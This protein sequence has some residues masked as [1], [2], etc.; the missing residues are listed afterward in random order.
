MIL[1]RNYH[2]F[3][4]PIKCPWW[5]LSSIM[6]DVWVQ[7]LTPNQP[8]SHPDPA[9]ASSISFCCDPYENLQHHQPTPPGAE[10]MPLICSWF[11]LPVR[12]VSVPG[13]V[14][15]WRL[16]H[17]DI[18]PCPI[19]TKKVGLGRAIF[20]SSKHLLAPPWQKS[21]VRMYR[22]DLVLRRVRHRCHIGCC[23]C[24]SGKDVSAIR[25]W[26]IVH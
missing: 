16:C 15:W 11:E 25:W 9:I 7:K 19:G 8:I 24:S 26:C 17:D 14:G 18:T 21:I 4:K 1:H 13:V 12:L 5:E 10:T 6:V 23:L 3:I 2:I 22:L 20:T